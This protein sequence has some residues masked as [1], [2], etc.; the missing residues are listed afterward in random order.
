V[1]NEAFHRHDYG[2]VHS[3]ANDHSLALLPMASLV[4]HVRSP[5]LCRATVLEEP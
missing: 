2:L 4:I 1:L 5:Y 3:V